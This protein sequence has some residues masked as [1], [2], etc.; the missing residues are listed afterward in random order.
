MEAEL[1]WEKGFEHAKDEF[2]EALIYHRMCSSA[3]CWKTIGAFTEGLKN[4]KYKKYKIGT[5]KDN[6]KICYLV[7]GWE[8]C[9]TQ[10]SKGG[11]TILIV[12]LNNRLKDL[13]RLWGG[14]NKWVVTANPDI[15]VPQR[16]DI[17]IPGQ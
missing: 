11:V 8:K 16:R 9:K 2:I 3:A 10:C 7:L 4:L 13:M 6:I 12:D 5:L 14:G 15:S 1:T 17:Y